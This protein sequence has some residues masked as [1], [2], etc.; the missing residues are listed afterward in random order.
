M[1]VRPSRS[2]FDAADAAAFPVCFFGAAFCDNALPAADFDALLVD[3]DFR[4][5]EAFRAAGL[6]VTFELRLAIFFSLTFQVQIV[7]SLIL[8]LPCQIEFDLK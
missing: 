4:V 6:L 8:H 1:L 7:V 5:F 2:V 3:F